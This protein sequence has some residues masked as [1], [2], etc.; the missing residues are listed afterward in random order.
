MDQ[1]ILNTRTSSRGRSAP[2]QSAKLRA[3]A[4]ALEH[5]FT[6]AITARRAAEE[7]HHKLEDADRAKD[8]FLATVSHELRTPLSP[9]VTW[10]EVLKRGNLDEEQSR[11]AVEA[12]QRSAKVQTQLIED[13]LDVSRI[14]AG[15]MRLEVRPVDLADVIRAAVDVVRPAADAKDIRV[16]TVIDTETAPVSGD[17][18]RLQQVVG[19]LLSNAV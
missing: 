10:A 18:D 11:L 12:I 16:Q 1:R 4:T 8:A 7:A 19:N 6:V 2:A 5:T 15:K 17:P 13:L 14:A 9:I 3:E